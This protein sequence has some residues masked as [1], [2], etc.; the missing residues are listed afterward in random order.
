MED[1]T[2]R[3]SRISTH[4]G[5]KVISPT[6]RPFYTIS[7]DV[8]HQETSVWMLFVHSALAVRIRRLRSLFSLLRTKAR[9]KLTVLVLLSNQLCWNA[10]SGVTLVA[11]S[12]T[13]CPLIVLSR[14]KYSLIFLIAAHRCC[15]HSCSGH[16]TYSIYL[17]WLLALQTVRA[18]CVRMEQASSAY[19]SRENSTLSFFVVKG[20]AADATDAPQS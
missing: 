20:P 15:L 12:A 4:K 19:S 10:L 18:A 17:Y 7:F 6:N 14:W 8:T 16:C 11:A 5:G 13:A 9:G 2:S 1:K 3:I